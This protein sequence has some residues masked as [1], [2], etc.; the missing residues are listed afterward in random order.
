MTK[1]IIYSIVFLILF[2]LGRWRVGQMFYYPDRTVYDTPASHGL[3]FEEVTFTSKDGTR[4]S[5]WFLPAVGA[6]KGTVIHFHGNAEN[7]TSHYDFVS[8]L[9]SRGFNLFVFDYRGYGKSAGRPTKRGVYED[10]HAALAYVRSRKDVDLNRLLLLGQSLGGTQAIAVAGSDSMQGIRAVVSDST[11][12]SCHSIVRDTIA[13]MP[14]L[15]FFKT[16]LATLLIS[17]DLSAA[18]AIGRIA[19]VPLLL[20]HGTRDSVIPYDHAERLLERAGQ[21]KTLWRIDGGE[22]TDAFIASDSPYRKQLVAFFEEV[23]R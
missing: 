3:R 1:I 12:Y 9:P 4:L 17:D 14:L 19:P 8:W 18:E 11:F 7:M 22:H 16:P 20:I 10:S 6:A 2:L 13:K 23:L 21:P 15:S 5:G